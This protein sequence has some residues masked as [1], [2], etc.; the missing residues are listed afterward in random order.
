MLSA[1]PHNMY[2]VLEVDLFLLQ[3]VAILRVLR[4]CA[5]LTNQLLYL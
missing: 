1:L 3:Q 5:H 2:Y 4:L